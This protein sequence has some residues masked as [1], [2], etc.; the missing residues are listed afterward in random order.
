MATGSGKTRMAVTESYRLLRY[1]GFN[2]VTPFLVDR[3]NLGDQTMRESASFTTPDDGPQVHRVVATWPEFA[4]VPGWW[5]E[6]CRDLHNPA[7]VRWS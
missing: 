4:Q 1:G 5:L 7:S 2:L 3:N 6:Q